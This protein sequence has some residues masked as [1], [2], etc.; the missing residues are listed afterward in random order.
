MLRVARCAIW[1]PVLIVLSINTITLAQVEPDE[2]L[3]AKSQ[4]PVT[5]VAA[6]LPH[7][8]ETSVT[9]IAI[10]EIVQA[11]GKQHPHIHV[12]PFVMPAIETSAMDSGPLM[13]I[14]AGIPPNA[15]YVNFR[16]SSTYINRGFL[17][18][19]EILL[20]RLQS[21]D[22][23][24]RQTDAQGRWL[25][26]PTPQEI[27][28]ALQQIKQRVP[29]PAWPVA[30]RKSL[31]GRGPHV[32]ALP[33]ANVV[34]A[35]LYRKDLFAEAGLDPNRPPQDWGELLTYAR[36]LTIPEKR[37]YAFSMP[38]DLSFHTYSLLVSNGARVLQKDSG[39]A[40]NPWRAIY[41]SREAA[42]AYAYFWELANGRFERDGEVI[43]GTVYF[44]SD[45]G[46]QKWQ[47]GEVAMQ[48]NYLYEDLLARIN[49]QQVGIAPVPESFNGTRGSE[50]NALMLGVFSDASAA[51]QLATMQYIWFFTGPQ[52]SEIRT[53]VYIE[54]GFGQFVNPELLKQYG[55]ERL[56]QRVPQGWQQAFDTAMKNGVPE[57]YGH[58]TQNVYR[59]LSRPI[60]EALETDMHDITHEERV[61]AI[62]GMLQSSADEF[63]VKVLG[64]LT[65]QQ[66]LIRRCVAAAVMLLVLL[67]FIYGFVYIWRFFSRASQAATT[68]KSRRFSWGYALVVPGLLIVFFWM[69]VPMLSGV[70]MAVT[71][72]QLVLPSTFAGLDNFAAVLFDERFWLSFART[73]YFVAL[74]IVLGFWPPIL[75]AILLDEIPTGFLKY[76]YRTIF[77]LPAVISGIIVMFLWKQLY[78]PTAYGPLNQV[79]LSVNSLGPLVA[80]LLKLLIFALWL[81]L[82]FITIRLPWK[83]DELSKWMRFAIW[84]VAFI[85]AA[86]PLW[87]L[88]GGDASISDNLSGLLL[89]RFEIEP[90][91]YLQSA[92]IAMI[93]CVLPGVWAASGPGCLLYLAALKTIPE[94]LYEAADVDGASVWH[95]VFYITL[96]QLK[97]LIVIQFIAAVVAAFKGS[98]DFI[99]AMTGGGPNDATMVLALEIFMRAFL[100]LEFG[101]A[102]A[103][104]WLL[105]T[106]LLGFTAYQIC[107]LSKAEFKAGGR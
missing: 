60:L 28:T 11:F 87:L 67:A 27:E 100:D 39:N 21:D 70:L 85:I 25:A 73:L 105:G 52:A 14:A 53:R 41:D 20:A 24:V 50:V 81:S 74:T 83:L 77:Y 10:R 63:N 58:N 98:A 61:D 65:P 32:W 18:P 8:R 33:Y 102:A 107:L 62:Q 16:Q 17:A 7:P 96:P 91:R 36:Q 26:D 93:C 22:P 82:L 80:S 90:L 71:D 13:A 15:I 66:V 4:I 19:L 51:K 49:P 38:G 57:P 23:R 5:I 55:Y 12:K 64:Q 37:Q 54:H 97:F 34:M 103:M 43:E 75:L 88:F 68:A 1:I 44:G 46:Y 29:E 9:A 76:V 56:L 79:I 69:Y 59:Y 45:G 106:V 84:A 86:G 78:D 72:F 101:I 104:A 89:G 6:R 31:D 99:L 30:Y 40:K 2:N 42:E 3:D 35:L 47:R 48:F 94:D 92:D 95:K